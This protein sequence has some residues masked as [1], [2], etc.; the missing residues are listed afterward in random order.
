[1]QLQN[2]MASTIPANL[3]AI[4]TFSMPYVYTR[5]SGTPK[6]GNRVHWWHAYIVL[7][8]KSAL[9]PPAFNPRTAK[10]DETKLELN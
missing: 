8:P 10:E 3:N 7:L 9:Q 6:A 4:V 2:R 1:M 5:K